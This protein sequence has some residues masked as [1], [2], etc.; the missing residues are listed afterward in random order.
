[1]NMDWSLFMW[2]P[3]LSTRGN[4][5]LSYGLV[6]TL[7]LH[8]VHLYFQQA[9]RWSFQ[10]SAVSSC[11]SAPVSPWWFSCCAFT[12]AWAS[13][14]GTPWMWSR[15]N[16]SLLLGGEVATF[17]AVYGFMLNRHVHKNTGV[18]KSALIYGL[19][20]ALFSLL[21]CL[22]PEEQALVS[23]MLCVSCL[24][25]W[26]TWYLGLLLASQRLSPSSWRHLC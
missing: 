19:F 7:F 18:I 16:H 2:H 24:Q 26:G 23:A 13:L 4:L 20:S 6:D 5:I 17:P 22:P 1:M 21:I 9:A 3:P 8:T 25:C 14:P 10:A 12:M 11:G 15:L